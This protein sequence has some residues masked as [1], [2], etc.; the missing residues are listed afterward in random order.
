MKNR[1]VVAMLMASAMAASTLAGCG[2]SGGKNESTAAPAAETTV[3]S[4]ESEGETQENQ[5]SGEAAGEA[6]ADTVQ[7]SLMNSKP[8]ITDALEAG[9]AKFGEK[10]NVKVE[11]YET[12]NPGDT[13]A[14]KYAAGDA[15]TL[16]IVDGAQV[17]ELAGEKI[18]D[19]SS[20]SWCQVGGTELGYKVDGKVYGMPLTIEGMCILYNKTAVEERLGKEFVPEDYTSLDAFT[21][22]V[23]DLKAAG[24][25]TPTILNSED[26][27]IGQKSY[28]FIYDY[29]DGTAAGAIAFLKDVHEGKTT[30]EDNDVFGKVYDAFDLFIANNVNRDDPLAADYDLN[31]SYLAEGEA[32]FWLN[33]TWAWPDFAPY[34]VHGSEYG[35]LPFPIN[36]NAAQGKVV[37]DA[38]KYV[39]LDTVN[40]SEDQQKA[41]KMLLDWLVFDEEGQDVLINQCGIVTAF[42]NISLPPTNPFNEGLQAYIE[43]GNTAAGA[44]YMPSDHR[45]VLAPNMQ[46]YLDGKMTR[47]EIAQKLDEYWTANLP[48][49]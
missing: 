22:L 19:L 41:A 36:D 20:E 16:A 46:A 13:I 43:A 23:E 18:A 1:R 32:A 26:W 33:G 4:A 38:T 12:D 3:Q 49:E 44:K 2:G 17:K 31:A 45:S 21:A 9:V 25:E 29:Q 34:A 37:A 47:D 6:F 8:E 35:V 39:T 28:Q 10:Y 11:V 7:I 15:P 27:S 30:F 48:V 24:M 5:E 42:T 14:Q 40:A